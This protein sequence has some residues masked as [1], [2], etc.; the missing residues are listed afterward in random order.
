MRCGECPYWNVSPGRREYTE[1]GDCYRAIVHLNPGLKNCLNDFGNN[2]VVPF[3][4]H[5]VKYF[6]NSLTFKKEYFK[7]LRNL[8]RGVRCVKVRGK[9]YLQTHEETECLCEEDNG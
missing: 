1:W 3:D 8:P 7:A 2:F 5:D 4:P 6:K 9:F